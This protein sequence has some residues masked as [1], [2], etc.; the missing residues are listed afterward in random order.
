M[1]FLRVTGLLG[2]CKWPSKVP[3]T[4]ATDIFKG[5]RSLCCWETAGGPPKSGATEATDISQGHWAVGK[6]QVAYKVPGY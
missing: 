2:K 1:T 6:V 5:T 3:A 4:E